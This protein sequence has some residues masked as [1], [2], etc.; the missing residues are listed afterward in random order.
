MIV[1][2]RKRCVVM[3]RTLENGKTYDVIHYGVTANDVGGILARD[4]TDTF[5]HSAGHGREPRPYAVADVASTEY[6]FT[7]GL[8]RHDQLKLNEARTGRIRR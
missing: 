7:P 2:Y 5:D 1:D 8:G 3:E 4:I 6:F